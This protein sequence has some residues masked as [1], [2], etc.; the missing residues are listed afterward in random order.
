[1]VLKIRPLPQLFRRLACRKLYDP[2]S[3]KLQEF[4][5]ARCNDCFPLPQTVEKEP[6]PRWRQTTMVQAEVEVAVE[7]EVEE[8]AEAGRK[9]EE[10][11]V[12]AA[13]EVAKVVGEDRVE[14]R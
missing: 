9:V 12:K 14:A 10:E 8:E 2:H 6:L 5:S 13:V 7:E 3:R 4:S 11:R 1:M